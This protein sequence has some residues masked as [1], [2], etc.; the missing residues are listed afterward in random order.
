VPTT[1]LALQHY[2]T[3]RN[4][5]KDFPCTVDYVNRF[6]TAKQTK[7]TLKK[8]KE[9]K[10]DILI[11]T[12][13]IVSKD[14]IFKDIGLL[15]IDEEQKFGVSIKEKL[16]QFRA[17]V[18]TLT[19]TATPIP[20][21]L[22]FSLM[23]AR[24]LSIINT[25]PPNRNPVQTEIISFGEEAIRD[26][27]HYELSRNGQVYFV[28]NRVQNITE[29]AG[30]I[31]R[32]VPDARIA[33]GHGQM[34]GAKLERIML[35]FIDIPNANTILI[36][37][38]Q[39]YGLSDLHQLR[40]RV[41]RSNKQAFCYLLS[42]PLSSLTAEARKR[43]Q[44]LEQFSDLGSGINI[45]MRD[46]DIR[47]AGN[48]LGAEQSGFISDIGYEMYQKI[49]NEAMNELKENEF[50]ELYKDED[51]S[52]VASDCQVETDLEI[53]IPD[54]YIT[55][56]AERLALYKELD[57]IETE[58]NLKI[59]ENNL[60]DRFGPIPLSVV[61]LLDTIRLRWISK[62]LGFEK[63]VLKSNKMVCF[64]ISNQDSDYFQSTIFTSILSYIQK[65][66]DKCIIKENKNRLSMIFTNISSIKSA[67]SHIMPIKEISD[68]NKKSK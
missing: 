10:I 9:G 5:L 28:H 57:H 34:D 29:V 54:E 40:G 13:R 16:K 14:I 27:I 26:A 25:P 65:N 53:L 63:L 44:A 17:N 2:K 18:D 51:K 62:E 61:E 64:F 20:R 39:N 59:F 8:L 11:G 1:I 12:H 31:S 50:K 7:E 60:I 41:G 6:K 43:L 52:I 42:P 45:A 37:D 33:I 68:N 58:E 35:E 23:G 56:I 49:L 36:N 15:I 21:T 22:Q 3:F 47:G 48:I 67:L 55:N 24:D 46:L 4:R 30:M 19:L 32:F 66:P 38:A